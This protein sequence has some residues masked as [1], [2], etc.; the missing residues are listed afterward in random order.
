M[1]SVPGYCDTGN[2]LTSPWHIKQYTYGDFK[3]RKNLSLS[4]SMCVCVCVCVCLLLVSLPAVKGIC[5]KSMLLLRPVGA[6]YG[7]RGYWEARYRRPDDPE[8]FEWYHSYE[9]VASILQPFLTAKPSPLSNPPIRHL[10]LL[11]F[12]YWTA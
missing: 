6:D 8:C 4:L 2:V 12:C 3:K 9:E 10:H 11:S 7:L 1:A 5:R